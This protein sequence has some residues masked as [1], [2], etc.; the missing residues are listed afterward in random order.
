M[1]LMVDYCR[2][3][4]AAKNL[5][6]CG[7]DVWCSRSC[8][9]P[10]KLEMAVIPK[11]MAKFDHV[12]EKYKDL[13]DLTS[14]ILEFSIVSALED[15][16][17]AQNPV[18]LAEL[19]RKVESV[20]PLT[21][22]ASAWFKQEE[23]FALQPGQDILDLE[24]G[25][26]Q[27]ATPL[28]KGRLLALSH[29]MTV[30]DCTAWPTDTGTNEQKCIFGNTLGDGYQYVYNAGRYD[31]SALPGCGCWCCRKPEVWPSMMSLS[32]RPL[33][34]AFPQSRLPSP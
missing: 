5:E 1:S 25:N 15:N 17:H 2:S 34:A 33:Q 16:A 10:T 31:E 28:G 21:A 7:S 8:E 11:V 20:E 14:D 12:L 29:T 6:C 23:G 24:S 18:D 3:E 26:F 32:Q 19:R 30:Y 22:A 9:Q 27:V 4:D 13:L